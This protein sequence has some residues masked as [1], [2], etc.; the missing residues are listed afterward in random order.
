MRYLVPAGGAAVFLLLMMT[1]LFGVD[2]PP[3]AAQEPAAPEQGWEEAFLFGGPYT[4]PAL[5]MLVAV[6]GVTGGGLIAAKRP[7]PWPLWPAL[8]RGLGDA[9]F[10]FAIIT[11]FAAMRSAMRTVARVGAAV[12]HADLADG[13]QQSLAD[14]TLGAIVALAG[15]CGAALVRWRL[16]RLRGVT[17]REIAERFS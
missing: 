4:Y 1:L 7:E 11:T 12:T 5:L 15:L 8:V 16:A 13:F 14:L 3:A 17:S 2:L 9:G 10:L 6:V